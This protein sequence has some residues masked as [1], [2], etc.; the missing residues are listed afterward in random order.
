MKQLINSAKIALIGLFIFLTIFST[1]AEGLA[2]SSFLGSTTLINTIS[3]QVFDPYNNPVSDVYVE[4][5]NEN[6]STVARQRISA[7][8]FMFTGISAGSYKVKVLT[9]GTNYFEQTQDVQIINMFRG[10][11][12][13]QF[14]DFHLKFD[15]RK[16]TLGSGGAPE[17]VFSQ[18]GISD[19]A[20][21]HYQR[22]VEQ[23]ANKKE[24]GLEELEQALQISPNYF[25]ALNRLGTEYVQRKEYQKA[26]PYLIKAI[27]INQR[28][29]SSFYALGYAAYQMNRIPEAIEAARA[30]TIIKPDAINAHWLYGTVLRINGNFDKSEKSLLQAKTLSKRNSFPEINWQLALLYNRLG[31]YKDAVAE[32][33]EYLKAQPNSRNK[34]EIQDLIGQ[35]QTKVK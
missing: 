10:A 15:P 35:L 16:V 33:E 23:L 6:Y 8:R 19:Q 11:S 7:G 4:L 34:K 3:G 22:G 9:S 24:K 17:Q 29:F 14:L 25:D 13:Q 21:K 26:V 32:L 12:D 1:K 2:F 18:E 27:D 20:R 31:R 5:I 30:T 28:S